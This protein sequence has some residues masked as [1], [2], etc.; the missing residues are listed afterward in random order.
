MSAWVG[1]FDACMHI[2]TL[3]S[4][5]SENLSQEWQSPVGKK[6][7]VNVGEVREA[8]TASRGKGGSVSLMDWKLLLR[9]KRMVSKS[10]MGHK[11]ESQKLDIWYSVKGWD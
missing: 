11:M 2:P 3:R 8:A 10:G 1:V 4:M 5:C 7:A 9:S 6:E